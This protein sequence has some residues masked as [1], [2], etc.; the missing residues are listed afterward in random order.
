MARLF[1]ARTLILGG[2]AL[3]AAYAAKQRQAASGL[4][5]GGTSTPAPAPAPPT[6]RSAPPPPRPAPPR[7]PPSPTPTSP[8]PPENTAT[9]VPA[10][11]PQVHDPAG[12]IDEAAEEAAAAAEA[13]NIG[14]TPE[15]YPSEEDPTVPADEAIRPLEE[16]G[17]GYSEG[18]ELAEA[19][20]VDNAEPAA[21]DPVEGERQIDEVIEAQDDRT[22][23]ESDE[24]LELGDVADESETA[25]EAEDL[26]ET[27]ETPAGEK[28][29]AVWR[30]DPEPPAAE[31]PLADSE[32][33]TWAGPS[34]TDDDADAEPDDAPRETQDGA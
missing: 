11:E 16:A 14:G 33:Q 34:V 12:G 19:D 23:G 4:L 9:H 29:S 13:A 20:L 8:G 3:G 26:G 30:L 32:F 7:P 6:P 28:G 1:S 31:E 2:L 24:V 10:P 22:T 25:V 18:Q 17:E 21:G 15:E 5:G 27:P